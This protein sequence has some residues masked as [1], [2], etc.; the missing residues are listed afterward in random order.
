MR[1]FIHVLT[2]CLADSAVIARQAICTCV[3]GSFEG[4]QARVEHTSSTKKR[5]TSS[6]FIGTFLV[7]RLMKHFLPECVR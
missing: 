3:S 2:S 4:G 1:E 5:T 7:R 6:D